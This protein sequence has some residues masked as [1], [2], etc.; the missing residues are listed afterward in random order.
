MVLDDPSGRLD[1]YPLVCVRGDPLPASFPVKVI[2]RI[3]GNP[4]N[5]RLMRQIP[6]V[7]FALSPFFLSFDNNFV[8]L[9]F[10]NRLISGCLDLIKKG[11]L[12]VDLAELL[13]LSAE[14]VGISDPDLFDQILQLLVHAI[15]LFLHADDQADQLLFA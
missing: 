3:I 1:P 11:Q 2:E 5:D 13:C 8:K 14:T 12:S 15:E 10:R 6:E 9:W 7:L 4:V